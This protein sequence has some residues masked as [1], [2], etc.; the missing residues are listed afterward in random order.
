V[1]LRDSLHFADAFVQSLT[2]VGG[3]PESGGT[4]EVRTYLVIKVVE[5]RD[6][7]RVRWGPSAPDSFKVLRPEFA[8]VVFPVTDSAGGLWVGRLMWPLQFY[9]RD[10]TE[11]AS[12][13][14][15]QPRARDDAVRLWRF[16]E[17]RRSESDWRMALRAARRDGPYINRSVAT[18]ILANFADRDSTWTTLIE[19]LRD[20]NGSVRE[21]AKMVL[22]N[23]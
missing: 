19:I 8:E 4:P 23:L 3:P 15:R 13:L 17:R 1:T 18:M 10:S 12:A 14:E 9:S 2:L 16:L 6:S 22:A 7:A 20:P 21:T 11:R 5:P